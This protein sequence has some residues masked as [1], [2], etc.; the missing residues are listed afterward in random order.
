M[1]AHPGLRRFTVVRHPVAWAHTAFCDRIVS[2]GPGSFNELRAT[3]RK[4]HHID[5]PDTGPVP[6]TDP[7][8]DMAAHRTAFLAFL[9]FLRGNLSAQTNTRVDPAWGS[10]LSMLQGMAEFGLPDMIMREDSLR[11]DLALLAGQLGKETMPPV[12]T[13][14]DPLRDR[15]AAIYDAEIEAATREAYQRDYMTFGFADWR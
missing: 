6:E 1:I 12:P 14:T 15:L 3:L 9:R 8:Y 4:V 13:V 2:N 7:V 10:Q 11:G 5:V